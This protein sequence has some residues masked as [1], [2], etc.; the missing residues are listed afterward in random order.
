MESQNSASS[1]G[2][3]GITNPLSF[4]TKCV[5]YLDRQVFYSIIGFMLGIKY[6]PHDKFKEYAFTICGPVDLT[7]ITRGFTTRQ[8]FWGG[9]E[10]PF[11]SCEHRDLI[12]RAVEARFEKDSAGRFVLLASDDKIIKSLAAVESQYLPT[13]T[14]TDQNLK[15][16]VEMDPK[17]VYCEILSGIRDKYLVARKSK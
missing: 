16:T 1:K 8:V 3:A 12:K 14:F 17:D 15:I 7:T 5:C 10:I 2:G 11:G 6:R 13:F 4:F 9:R